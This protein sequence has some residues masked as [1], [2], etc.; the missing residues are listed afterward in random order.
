MDQVIINIFIT[1]SQFFASLC[2]QYYQVSDYQ[3][4]CFR[5]SEVFTSVCLTLNILWGALCPSFVRH[6][7]NSKTWKKYFES[8]RLRSGMESKFG[9]QDQENFR[10]GHCIF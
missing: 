5:K 9:Q 4:W 2:C 3:I 1:P 7:S 10:L 6:N 8:D